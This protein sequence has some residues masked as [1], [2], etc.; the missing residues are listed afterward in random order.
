MTIADKNAIQNRVS[1][2]G[3]ALIRTFEGFSAR[4]YRCPAGYWTIGYGHVMRPGEHFPAEIDEAAAAT[5]LRHDLAAAER[6]VRR[7]IEAPLRQGQ[8][9][10]LASFTFNLGAGALQRSTLRRRANRREHALAA[11]EF[12]RWVWA[13][14]RKLPGLV[15]RRAAEALLYRS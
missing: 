12:S 14:G 6:A 2:R 11:A 9:D 10:A 5:L 15:R 8:F 7:L 4:P 1:E 13:G 3:L